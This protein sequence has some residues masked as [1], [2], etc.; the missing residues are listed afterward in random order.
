MTDI[1]SEILAILTTAEHRLAFASTGVTQTANDTSR[2]S[3]ATDFMAPAHMHAHAH[4]VT[5][6]QL[7]ALCY[8]QGTNLENRRLQAFTHN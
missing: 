1:S 6:R 4:W 2:G 8:V 7:T 3:Y 5:K